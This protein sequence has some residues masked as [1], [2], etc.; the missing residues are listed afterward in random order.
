MD[1]ES[2]MGSKD[3]NQSS[4]EDLL[5]EREKIEK[6]IADQFQEFVTIM[7]T[8]IAGYTNFVETHGDIAAK[9][10]LQKHNA[11]IYPIITAHSGTII[12]TIGDAIM[13]SFAVPRE[14]VFAAVDIQKA[15]LQHNS[16]VQAYQQI[17]IRIGIHSGNALK[18]GDDYFGDA[19]NI[20]ARIEPTA[21][22]GQ[23]M[24]SKAVH[25]QIETMNDI[26]C[27]YHG[28]KKAKGKSGP[29][30]LYRVFLSPEEQKT[31]K[32]IEESGTGDEI[33]SSRAKRVTHMPLMWKVSL[34][35]VLVLI[36]LFVYPGFITHM[37]NDATRKMQQY[38]NGFMY[39]RNGD[40]DSAK[41]TFLELGEKDPRANEGLA[42]LAY[43]NHLYS[44]AD[45]LSEKSLELNS[46]ILYPRVIKGN[47][48][49][50][51]GRYD[52]AKQL[53]EEATTLDTPLK[54]Q[55]G[56]AF[57]RLGRIS[58]FKENT[59]A[60][61]DYYNQAVQYDETNSE[62]LAA[63]GV[64]LE[65]M[66]ELNESLALLQKARQLTPNDPY[67]N[68]FSKSVQQKLEAK[69][70][71]EK[72]ERID[73]L[74]DDLI[75]AM[76]ENSPEPAADPWTS[77]PVTLFFARM[78]R[79]GTIPLREG[80][81]E[82]FKLEIAEQLRQLDRVEVVDRELL[83]R[84]L[85]E[86]KM[87]S[88]GLADTSMALQLGRIVS[89]RLIGNLAFVG[90]EN[91]TR[92][93]LNLIETETSSVKISVSHEFANDSDMDDIIDSIV[94]TIDDEIKKNFPARGKIT[95]MEDDRVTINIGSDMGLHEGMMMKVLSGDEQ[96]KVVGAVRI[97]S[98]LQDMA[99]GDI[100]KSLEPVR[101]QDLLEAAAL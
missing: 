74:V 9:S 31:H 100:V 46:S 98:V 96:K 19:V 34:P 38:I 1:Q 17:H 11:I 2:L 44:E 29:L 54:W 73:R 45:S 4:I 99:K 21:D 81:D 52:D 92:L 43:R 101:E 3:K 57:F 65:K 79:K 68:A 6:S 39:L 50:D 41:Q 90:M 75:S 55:K 7:F 84:L 63:K 58:S 8:D 51:K 20:A 89:A 62:I 83:D 40:F 48:M 37:D 33:V 88:S 67:I 36:L 82:F 72:Q 64:L 23:I 10:L 87:S 97:T 42:A 27:S 25:D 85:Q 95:G 77:R 93:Y 12:K 49:F 15:L 35:F 32:P 69:K 14:A 16:E 70:D 18:D 71:K 94:S 13:A 59:S 26:L 60:A 53:Y 22:A 5:S 66:G 86:L 28:M 78:E 56:E 91:K 24:V 30:E 80:Q 76:K 47:I 61:L